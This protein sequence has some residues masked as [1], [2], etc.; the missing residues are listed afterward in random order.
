MLITA[1]INNCAILVSHL[2]ELD[3]KSFADLQQGIK[4]VVTNLETNLE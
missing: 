2:N 4:L 1:V 3:I